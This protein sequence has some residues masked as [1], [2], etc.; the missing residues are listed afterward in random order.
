MSSTDTAWAALR[1]RVAELEAL[2]GVMQLLEWD[3]QTMMPSGGAPHRGTQLSTL[4]GLMHDRLSD[5]VIGDWLSDLDAD[6]DP[7]R[8]AAVRNVRRDHERAIKVPSSLVSE[9]AEASNSGFSAW[10]TAREQNSF[11]PFQPALERLVDLRRKEISALGPTEEPYDH[12]LDQY[13]PGST[14][15][16]LRPIF[17]RL[18]GELAT[19]L[20]EVG[21]KEGP[22][23]VSGN[24]D[25]PGQQRLSDT[26]ISAIGFRLNDGRLDASQHPFTVGMG[27]GDV[28]L[29][30]HLYPDDLL[31]G[32]T[33]TVHEAGH[34]MYEQGLPSG[35]AGTSLANAA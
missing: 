18:R 28:R 26:V 3:Q 10:M 6:T 31:G 14:T 12:L 1:G 29:T 25:L 32:L 24:W 20:A 2:S 11:A 27:A 7:I 5:P 34:G 16:Q 30:T 8:S 22:P 15:A 9:I 13:D 19:F 21:Q 4:S 17:A 33:G 23:S 35:Q